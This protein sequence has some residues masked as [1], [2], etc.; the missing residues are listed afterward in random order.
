M[1]RQY[2]RWLSI[3]FAVFLL[4]ISVTGFA[5]HVAELVANGGFE[6]EAAERARAPRA[7]AA[8]NPLIPAAQAHEQDEPQPP[9]AAA[10]SPQA[11]TA[12]ATPAAFTCPADMTCRPK[13]PPTG[14]R[15]WVGWL[16]HIHAGTEF[17]PVGVIISMMSGLALFFFAISGLWM[18]YELYRGRLM[19]ARSGKP[20]PGGKYFWK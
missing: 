6:N 17:G 16:H 5:S 18:Y 9:Q 8:G 7:V 4:W 12:A 10:T 14:A 11:A 19:R 13:A 1:M 2:H 3:I 15:A 20:A